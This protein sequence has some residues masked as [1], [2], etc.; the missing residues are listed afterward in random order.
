MSEEKRPE[1]DKV[2]FSTDKLRKYFAKSYTPQRMEQTIIKLLEA[3][4][5]KRQRSQKR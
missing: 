1:T 4:M 5:K 2:T 3:W